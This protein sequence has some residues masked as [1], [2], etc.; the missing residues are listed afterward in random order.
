MSRRRSQRLE[1]LQVRATAIEQRA[2]L[3]RRAIASQ[4]SELMDRGQRSS[5]KLIATGLLIRRILATRRLVGIFRGPA[6]ALALLRLGL[7]VLRQLSRR[8]TS[9]AHR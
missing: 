6:G 2:S 9:T 8:G 1:A 3:E 4:C 5:W 7:V